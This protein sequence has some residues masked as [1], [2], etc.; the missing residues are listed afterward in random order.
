MK[1]LRFWFVGFCTWFFLLFN[2]ERLGDPINLASFVYVYAFIGAV[3]VLLIPT[4]QRISFPWLMAGSLLP[5]F[6]LKSLLGYSLSDNNLPIIVT[7]ICAVGFSLFLAAQ[8]GRRLE[9]IKET[10]ASLT[11]GRMG[12]EA[13]PFA[14]GQ[15]RIYSEIRRARL[16]ERPAT[17]L[18]ISATEE[19]VELSIDYFVQE[20]QREIIKQYI[21]ARISELLVK[22]LHDCDIVAR[23]DGH[24]I[25]LLPE[26]TRYMVEDIIQRIKE[27]AAE[28]LNLH[29]NIGL[30]TFPDEAVTFESLLAI[31]ETQMATNNKVVTEHKLPGFTMETKTVPTRP[32]NE[33]SVQTAHS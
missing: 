6:L 3:L 17:L 20:A 13:I 26:T 21:A 4:L 22:E 18:A 5:Y 23:R 28:K 15:A 27:N 30:A 19:S 29:L 31:A 8:L 33:P 7:E 32:S 12:D 24:F 9:S 11:I 14:S 16:Y 25:T 2:V 10:L 1:R